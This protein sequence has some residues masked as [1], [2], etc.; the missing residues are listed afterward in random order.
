[1][2]GAGFASCHANHT[3]QLHK[4]GTRMGLQRHRGP[5]RE[6]STNPLCLNREA[7]RG[8]IKPSRNSPQAAQGAA[9]PIHGRREPDGPCRIGA[10]PSAGGGA[11]PQGT[12]ATMLRPREEDADLRPSDGG[13]LLLVKGGSPTGLITAAD[14]RDCDADPV[15]P[16]ADLGVHDAD[17][18]APIFVITMGRNPHSRMRRLDAATVAALALDHCPDV[19]Q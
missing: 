8:E 1:M 14:P 13:L 15:I 3:F 10:H 9:A 7:T 5:D 19:R 12:T 11:G 17:H 2:V 4:N 6:G 18:D 16:M